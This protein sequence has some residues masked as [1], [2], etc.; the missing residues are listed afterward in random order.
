MSNESKENE[1]KESKENEST[2]TNSTV[3]Y[4]SQMALYGYDRAGNEVDP[5]SGYEDFSPLTPSPAPSPAPAPLEMSMPMDVDDDDV[6]DLDDTGNVPSPHYSP[7]SPTYPRLEEATDSL[8]GTPPPMDL[9]LDLGLGLG[10]N[11]PIIATYPTLNP[12]DPP[13]DVNDDYN[14]DSSEG[15]GLDFGIEDI[16]VWDMTETAPII[17][18][19][20]VMQFND[21]GNSANE[22][23]STCTLLRNLSGAF[24]V[25]GFKSAQFDKWIYIFRFGILDDQIAFETWISEEAGAWVNDHGLDE[26]YGMST[27]D[28]ST[29]LTYA[30]GTE[31]YHRSIFV[32][33][34]E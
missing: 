32:Q 17:T 30:R 11:A 8:R 16:Q 24:E 27:E 28:V 10:M 6:N 21:Q 2:E 14:D 4:D 23:V 20:L 26:M 5:L 25:H 33:T 7:T 1:R 13:D 34:I 12:V 9:D 22:L 19:A 29:W 18:H 3:Y 15:M 31:H